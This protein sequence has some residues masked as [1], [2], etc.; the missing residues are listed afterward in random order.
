M[1]VN[2]EAGG[3]NALHERSAVAVAREDV[4]FVGAFHAQFV[5]V[6]PLARICYAAVWP[7]GNEIARA[8]RARAFE[9]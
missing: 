9:G 8:K 4:A 6:N 1:Y 2:V 5:S 3:S 7:Q